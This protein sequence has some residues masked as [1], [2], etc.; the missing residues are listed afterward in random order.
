MQALLVEPAVLPSMNSRPCPVVMSSDFLKLKKVFCLS[1]CMKAYIIH[2]R[3]SFNASNAV[4]TS[5]SN[6]KLLEASRGQN[7]FAGAHKKLSGMPISDDH[8]VRIPHGVV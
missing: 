2:G 4:S 3:S 1:T 5:S 7:C 6:S 8:L